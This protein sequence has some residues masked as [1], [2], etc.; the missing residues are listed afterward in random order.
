MFVS[1]WEILYF[2][3]SVNLV[4]AES[5]NGRYSSLLSS[6][7]QIDHKEQEKEDWVDL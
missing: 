6:G 1:S 3:L 5:S 2:K 4:Q 7:A